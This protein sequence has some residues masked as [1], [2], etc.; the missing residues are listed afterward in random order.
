MKNQS[1]IFRIKMSFAGKCTSLKII[2]V[3]DGRLKINDQLFQIGNINVRG[4]NSEQVAAVLRQSA[5]H[6]QY[7]KFLVARPVHNSASEADLM[8]SNEIIDL[9][10][11]KANNDIFDI[12]L[13]VSK[14]QCF[15][16]KTSTI[17][18]KRINFK[19]LITLQNVNM[20]NEQCD[21]DKQD[22]KDL[23][24][25]ND[26]NK[27]M[28]R[29]ELEPKE[30]L[31]G[32]DYI[33][34]IGRNYNFD[35]N[36]LLVY[37]NKELN[38]FGIWIEK[39]E[40]DYF[41][42]AIDTLKNKLQVPQINDQLVEINQTQMSQLHT[43]LIVLDEK[44]ICFKFCNNFELKAKILG[45][46]WHD[47]LT[48]EQDNCEHH[49]NL[50]SH[51][52][53]I[54]VSRI[55]KTKSKNI[56]ISLEGTVDLDDNGI[57]KFPH[58][59]IRSIMPNGPVDT[60]ADTPFAIGDELLEIDSIKLY[61]ISYVQLLDHL[62]N[63]KNKQMILVCARRTTAHS[64][65]NG[66]NL[67]NDDSYNPLS[68]TMIVI[69]A[70]V[71]GGVA[72]LDGRLMPGQ[73]LV[74]V[75]DH[76]L[77]DDLILKNGNY[78]MPSS[79]I[80]DIK[81]S[82]SSSCGK[83]I[84][85][86]LLSYAVDILKSLPI[87]KVVRLG[88]QKPLPYPD[89]E[90]SS[91]QSQDEDFSLVNRLSDLKPRQTR[92]ET[93]TKQIEHHMSASGQ[94][95]NSE[96]NASVL[97]GHGHVKSVNNVCA[98]GKKMKH[99]NKYGIAATS[100]PAI[101]SRVQTDCDN[102]FTFY[103]SSSQLKLNTLT[104]YNQKFRSNSS[105]YLNDT[106]SKCRSC[107]THLNDL[108]Y[109]GDQV[110]SSL[111]QNSNSCLWTKKDRSFSVSFPLHTL[112]NQF[113][114]KH[115]ATTYRNFSNSI[116]FMDKLLLNEKQN[117]SENIRIESNQQLINENQFHLAFVRNSISSN[118]IES[119]ECRGPVRDSGPYFLYKV[120]VWLTVNPLFRLIGSEI[121]L[122]EMTNQTTFARPAQKSEKKS[123]QKTF[124]KK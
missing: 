122:S 67:K 70:L 89:A 21:L 52:L 95:S 71:P 102:L 79:S 18:D 119:F 6:G 115:C 49:A 78:T 25:E 118:I 38:H 32:N 48:N 51:H 68:K 91:V 57:E 22:Q 58:H 103:S 59:Y 42:Q 105:L 5:F 110:S 11:E 90:V 74:T 97:P 101:L 61:A 77:D 26:N 13:P 28:D 93:K 81:D 24:H 1:S 92:I 23:D 111:D 15:L 100:A 31:L 7:V 107:T 109:F 121:P 2:R 30:I 98:A 99:E 34:E 117:E 41:I 9:N 124:E 108:T 65:N 80:N 72:H 46:K 84:H 69:R 10:Q 94:E 88:I 104:L 53:K 112:S 40:Q 36:D 43:N 116:K 27:S 60:A 66:S 29:L 47:H 55:D 16:I 73:R 12:D 96:Q 114:A 37:V 3:K 86:D 113:N 54:I 35:Q 39:K 8:D 50:K 44:L 19:N 106:I 123:S 83:I 56:G 76:I 45:Q 33:V 17:V 85:I 63:L 14:S 87:G 4:M 120:T 20:D 82:L 75:N 64:Q 62:K